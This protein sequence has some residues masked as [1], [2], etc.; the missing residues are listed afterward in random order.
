MPIVII[1]SSS[2][3]CRKALAEDLMKKTGYQCLSREELIEEAT[4]SGI[5]VGKLEMAVIRT[6]V[7]RERLV[8]LKQLYLAFITTAVIEKMKQGNLIYY[9]RAGHLLLPGV[10]HVL[11]VRVIP[12][13]EYHI[14]EVMR[15]LNL[16]REKTIA[17]I[18]QVDKD[19]DN[20]VRTV[21]GV[22]PND[23]TQYDMFIN[24]KHMNL[25]NAAT[26]LCA[27][28]DLPDFRPTPA[29]LRAMENHRLEAQ[30]RVQLAADERTS[31]ADLRVTANDGVVTVTYMPRQAHLDEVIPKVC[32]DLEGCDEI[33]GTMAETNILWVQE[34]FDA[35]SEAFSQLSQIA[36]RWGAAIEL[37]RWIPTEMEENGDSAQPATDMENAGEMKNAGDGAAGEPG[38]KDVEYNG[39]IESDVE[40]APSLPDGGI[41]STLEKLIRLGK[42]GGSHTVVG[43]KEQLLSAISKDVKYSLV[44]VGNICLSKPHAVQM[45]MTRDLRGYLQEKLKTPIIESGELGAKFLFQK[46]HVAT[47]LT[48]I[49]LLVVIYFCAFHFQGPIL[50]FL[51]GAFHSRMPWLTSIIVVVFVPALAYLYGTV[52]GLLLKLIR[53]E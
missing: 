16:G 5:P 18:D 43:T 35:D 51:G 20:W 29:S 23:P 53:L 25:S 30:A 13:R 24:L 33:L 21:Y 19:V 42:S 28:M 36:Q 52:A 15:R 10:T 47:L 46:K 31:D 22:D 3:D 32:R 2:Y 44:V 1:S 37:L 26:A 17:Y 40:E 38:G 45:R 27:M 12:E 6:P 7:M 50:D 41:P 14:K 39:G 11:R 4:Q 49:P 9:G 34:T 48:L 8:R